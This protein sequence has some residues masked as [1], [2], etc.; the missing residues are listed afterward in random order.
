MVQHQE[1]HR[2]EQNGHLSALTKELGLSW[3]DRLKRGVRVEVEGIPWEGLV[4][5]GQTEVMPESET[6]HG[7]LHRT[8]NECAK[9]RV[10]SGSL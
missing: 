2:G 5:H 4:T 6:G 7:S 9:S 10:S 3:H 1:E 8:W